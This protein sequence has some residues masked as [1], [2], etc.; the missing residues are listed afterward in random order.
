LIDH[1]PDRD[2]ICGLALALLLGLAANASCPAWSL[3]QE[4]PLA[5]PAGTNT[6][7]PLPPARPSPSAPAI[8]TP[9]QMP[10]HEVTGE[11]AVP[12]WKPGKLLQLPPYTRPRMHECALEWQKMKESGAAAEKIWYI[13]AQSCLVR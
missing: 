7:P 10:E 8:D 2:A 4:A 5:A 13:F 3:A 1:R 12:A 9:R 11:T 6:A